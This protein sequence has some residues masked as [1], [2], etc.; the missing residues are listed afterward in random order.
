MFLR[1]NLAVYIVA[2]DE[3]QHFMILIGKKYRQ[4][5]LQRLQEVEI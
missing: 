3:V 5:K 1:K 4:I 2:L